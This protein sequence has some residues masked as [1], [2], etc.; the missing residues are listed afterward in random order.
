MCKKG[1]YSD[2]YAIKPHGDI[3]VLDL[4]LI[5][6]QL[7]AYLASIISVYPLEGSDFVYGIVV[8]DYLCL[9]LDKLADGSIPYE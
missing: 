5:R 2:I 4:N 1:V 3:Q 8:Y 9:Y 6:S 7:A